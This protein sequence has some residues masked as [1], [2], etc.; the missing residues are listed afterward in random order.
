MKKNILL[1]FGLLLSSL[2]ILAQYSDEAKK[3]KHHVY[4]SAG[5]SFPVGDFSSTNL[6][7]EDAGMAKTG[8]N[9]QLK[10]MYAPNSGLGVV[11]STFYAKHSLDKSS[12]NLDS[13]LS[14][15]HWQYYGLMVGPLFVMPI[16][17][18][19]KVD[20]YV[21]VGAGNFNTPEVLYGHQTI[22]EGKWSWA[23]PLQLGLDFRYAFN[24]N[25]SML[26]S[27]EFFYAKPKYDFEGVTEKVVQ[28]ISTIQLNAGIGIRF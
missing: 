3:T 4:F 11:A 28:K 16:T 2:T 21:Q 13:V 26:V 18:E 5:P 15:D 9:L 24:G 20:A 23:M 8:Y 12:F 6:D 22:M 25:V 7:N 10:Y 17:E 14:L 19:A 27:S 1:S